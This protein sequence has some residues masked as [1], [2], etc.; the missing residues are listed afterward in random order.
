MCSKEAR[1]ERSVALVI[2][3]RP[4][5]AEAAFSGTAKLSAL[6]A[7]LISF[8]L[9]YSLSAALTDPPQSPLNTEKKDHLPVEA[10]Q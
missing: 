3:K 7:S 4:A 2:F 10:V 9:T 1:A 5:D 8:R 6:A